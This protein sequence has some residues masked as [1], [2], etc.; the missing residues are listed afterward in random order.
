MG[1]VRVTGTNYL[2]DTNS[3]GLVNIDDA[4]KNEYLS[5][6]ALIKTQKEEINK[7]KSEIDS[8]KS[9]L[10]EIKELVIQLLNRDTN[11]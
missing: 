5:K 6:V 3:M 9:E 11:G 10:S 4:E 2:R 1:Y 7:V 8:F